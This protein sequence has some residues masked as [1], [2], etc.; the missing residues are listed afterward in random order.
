[1]QKLQVELKNAP[2]DVVLVGSSASDSL[3]REETLGEGCK[4]LACNNAEGHQPQ[5]TEGLKADYVYVL[6]RA[7]H[8]LMPC[9]PAKARKLL[10]AGKAKVVKKYPFT[11]QLNFECENKTQDVIVGIDPGYENVGFSAISDGREL[12]SG[13]MKLE[14][15]V[16]K[17]L[18]EKAMYRRGRRNRHHWYRKP[19]F[20]NRGNAK[21]GWLPPSVSRRLN[22]HISLV[23]NMSKLLPIS[24]INVEVANFDIQKIKNPEVSGVGY[25][26]GDLYGYK[27]MQ[28]YLIARESGKCQLCG[29][30]YDGNGW[31]QHH[32]IPRSKGGTDRTKNIAL[33][34][35]KCHKKLH[36]QGL[37]RKIKKSK[38]YRGETFMSVIR[39]SLVDKL[40]EMCIDVNITF[41][42]ITNIKRNELELEK[43]HVN[44]AFVIAGGEDQVRLNP[45]YKQQKRVHNRCLQTNRKDRILYK[46]RIR[47]K[48]NVGDIVLIGS[49]KYVSRGT[50]S[51]GRYV[52]INNKVDNDCNVLKG[53]K[54]RSKDITGHF[55]INNSH[56]VR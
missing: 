52:Y 19:R 10:K 34:H 47:Y 17:R 7:G 27:N 41:G 28:S 44:D 24:R 13:E 26:Q 11:I 50:G 31:Q 2:S 53:N 39:W 12:M 15:G 51:Y 32:I 33:L 8:P 1:M 22:A 5:Y 30:E 40:K 56:I 18:L 46:S 16:T 9:K 54:V 14:N 55:K 3:N 25:Q 23:R 6:G 36:E 38:Q 48:Y 37:Y 21:K 42:Y 45:Y 35:E 49:K 4:V 29:K 20:D 43:S